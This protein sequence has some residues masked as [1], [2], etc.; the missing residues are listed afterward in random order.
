MSATCGPPPPTPRDAASG[1]ATE[2]PDRESAARGAVPSSVSEWESNPWSHERA[3]SSRVRDAPR[4]SRLLPKHDFDHPNEKSRL[5]DPA[6]FVD[7]PRKTALNAQSL[8]L[9]R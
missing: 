6:A 4:P 7:N 9:T 8:G 5:G 3:A 1:R 2:T